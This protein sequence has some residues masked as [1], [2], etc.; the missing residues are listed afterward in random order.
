MITNQS[1]WDCECEKNYI[2]PKTHAMCPYCGA[3]ADDQPDSIAEEVGEML[4]ALEAQFAVPRKYL[5][6]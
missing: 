2:H 1:Y 4:K 6:R 5:S 3:W